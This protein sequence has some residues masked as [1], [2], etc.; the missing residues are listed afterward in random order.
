M[1]NLEALRAALGTS[2]VA[3]LVEALRDAAHTRNLEA[4]QR[5]GRPQPHRRPQGIRPDGTPVS[6]REKREAF[7]LYERKRAELRAQLEPGLP[8]VA[9]AVHPDSL[10][11]PPGRTCAWW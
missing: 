5:E 1:L 7:A 8:V 11:V 3:E 6:E 2:P 9:A 4:W 10:P